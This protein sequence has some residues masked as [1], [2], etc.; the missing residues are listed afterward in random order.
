VRPGEDGTKAFRLSKLS[1]RG[2]EAIYD[3]VRTHAGL[4]ECDCPHYEARLRGNCA[5]CC[6]HG[7]AL[8]ELG[9]MEAPRPNFGPI[10]EPS[11][12]KVITPADIFDRPEWVEAQI[13][14]ESSANA[15]LDAAA[16]AEFCPVGQIDDAPDRLTPAEVIDRQ[17]AAYLAWGDE[18]GDTIGR[19]LLELAREF[20][21]L[22]ARTPDEYW[23]R[24]E[25]L[26]RPDREPYH[27]SAG[28][29]GICPRCDAGDSP[30]PLY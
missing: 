20:R 9:L 21:T 15:P 5:D 14:G 11:P 6:K 30:H 4:V 12:A 26:L 8:V 17:A 1:S 23:A 7:R 25:T 3:V 13:A 2:D 29:A 16:P 22:G 10:G 27:C 24:R 18:L 28:D 19:H